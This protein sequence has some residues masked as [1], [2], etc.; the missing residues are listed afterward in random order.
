MRRG[1]RWEQQ[2]ERTAGA[3]SAGKAS[4]GTGVPGGA[5]V[6]SGL[7]E[8]GGHSESSE[9]G[10]TKRNEYTLSCDVDWG[11]GGCAHGGGRGGVAARCALQ[12]L[13]SIE[14]NG[15]SKEG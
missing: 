11:W 1:E 12:Q 13:K 6:R 2:R 7:G 4:K 8:A 3:Q 10:A 15:V 14:R 9:V 5:G